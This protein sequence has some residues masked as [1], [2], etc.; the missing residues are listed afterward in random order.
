MGVCI[1]T[2]DSV[3]VNGPLKCGDWPDINICLFDLKG[4]LAPGEKVE[5]DAGY[6]GD[7]CIRTTNDAE[8][9]VD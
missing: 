6:L 7:D 1:Q 8:N 5:A 4:R 3:W 9:M 2:S